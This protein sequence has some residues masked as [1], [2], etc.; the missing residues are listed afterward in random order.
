MQGNDQHSC[1][2]SHYTDIPLELCVETI[3]NLYVAIFVFE[4]NLGF[5]VQLQIELQN[6]D[7]KKNIYL[8]DVQTFKKCPYELLD[9]SS[10]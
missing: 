10:I 8:L 5:E 4:S 9:N 7:Y 1:F 3:V 2:S 6:A